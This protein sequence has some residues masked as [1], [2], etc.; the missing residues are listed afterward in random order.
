VR[1]YAR[2]A[3]IGSRVGDRFKQDVS[4][5]KAVTLRLHGPY[6]L[7]LSL[8]A[9]ESFSPG[10]AMNAPTFRAAVRLNGKPVLVEV[11]Q[12][13]ERPPLLEVSCASSRGI[14]SSPRFVSHLRGLAGWIL[15]ADLDLRPFYKVA[16]KHSTLAPIARRLRGAKPIR[17]ASLFEMAVIAITEQ[18]I[19]LAS[20]YRIRSRVIER[21]GDRAGG[22]WVFPSPERLARASLGQLKACGLSGKRAE[23]VNG[24][25]KK[26][27]NGSL[28]LDALKEMPDDEVRSFIMGQ[29]G[30]GRWSAEYILVRGLGRL[31]CV[32]IDD[33]G[34]RTIVG[35]HLG[36]GSR[37]TPT[38][39][40]KALEPL[41]PYRGLA[42]FYLLVH[43]RLEGARKPQPI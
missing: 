30:F 21:F 26:I 20:A 29:R 24:V 19:S 41:A 22:L 7:S 37:M 10:G 8:S 23:Y 27:A 12:V 11:R 16:A 17:P 28:D 35:R 42:T 4:M 43:S 18:Q 14:G 34:V 36:D 13:A 31:D 15:F 25:A 32:P 39:V 3:Q 33:L 9:A 5:T 2:K 6:S 40:Q 1:R 38:E